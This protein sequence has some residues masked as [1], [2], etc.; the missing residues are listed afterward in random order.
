[1]AA[2]GPQARSRS[3]ASGLRS[4]QGKS[5]AKARE[6]RQSPLLALS[7]G[8]GRL[9]VVHTGLGQYQ[10]KREEPHHRAPPFA[11]IKRRRSVT[12]LATVSGRAPHPSGRTVLSRLTSRAPAPERRRCLRQSH[13]QR[14]LHHTRGIDLHRMAARCEKVHTRGRSFPDKKQENR[15]GMQ[16]LASQ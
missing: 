11:S 10:K 1:M 14:D 6:S 9:Q 4:S 12:S 8:G 5:A 13:T 16:A 15:S 2:L 3:G 7:S